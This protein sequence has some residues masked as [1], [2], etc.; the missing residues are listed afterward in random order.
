MCSNNFTSLN[1][2]DWVQRVS[3]TQ[4]TRR[5]K[6][7]MADKTKAEEEIPLECEENINPCKKRKMIPLLLDVGCAK[8]KIKPR[9]NVTTGKF[10]LRELRRFVG[11]PASFTAALLDHIINGL[12]LKYPHNQVMMKKMKTNNPE[13]LII[14][15]KMD[16]EKCIEVLELFGAA[17]VFQAKP[18][19]KL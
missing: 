9:N 5:K 1:S 15:P 6:K 17:F 3:T 10:L 18:D 19:F 11:F 7:I 14:P 4:S 12:A 2:T 8:L 16:P 13:F